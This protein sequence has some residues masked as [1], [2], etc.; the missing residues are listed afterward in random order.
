MKKL[1]I[2]VTLTTLLFTNFTASYALESYNTNLNDYKEILHAINER[3]NSEMYIM[4][5]NE[6][7]SSPIS[8]QYKNSYDSYIDSITKIDLLTFKNEST[9]IA[10][11]ASTYNFSLHTLNKSILTSK[12]VSFYSG[13]NTM[14][15]TY[16][17][18]GNKFD[19]SYNP[20]AKVTKINST[21]YFIMSSYSGNFKNSNSTYSV[22]ALGKIYTTMGIVNNKSFIIN[23]NL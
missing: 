14:T 22:T 7:L 19:T 23:F 20:I 2:F 10:Q 12:T 16:K 9:V 15:L 4:G 1:L 5:E 11:E 8:K 17:Y 21:N 13:R 18:N 3:Y 6:F